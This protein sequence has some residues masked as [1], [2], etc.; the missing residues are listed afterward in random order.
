VFR[1]WSLLFDERRGGSFCVGAV[2]ARSCRP[3]PLS[4]AQL[5]GPLIHVTAPDRHCEATSIERG[6]EREKSSIHIYV[7]NLRLR[8]EFK[9]NTQPIYLFLGNDSVNTFSRE[10]THTKIGCLLLGNG[11]LNM[12]K[13]IR[14]NRRRCFLSG[15]PWSY[16]TRISRS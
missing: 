9:Y 3:P 10:P 14:D 12:T 15:P 5:P 4:R 8:I 13:T 6:R 2:T 11:S 16:I 7:E 1:K